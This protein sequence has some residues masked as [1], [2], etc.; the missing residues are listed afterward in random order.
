MATKTAKTKIEEIDVEEGMFLIEFPRKMALATVG[1]AFM[2]QDETSNMFNKLVDRGKE[3]EKGTR[4]RAEDIMDMPKKEQEK[5][6]NRVGD[7]FERVLGWFNIPTQ[8]DVKALNSKITTLTKKV[9]QLNK[10]KV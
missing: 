8:T 9:D 7:E 10:A 2:L 6:T 5:L 1:A 4:E 3:F